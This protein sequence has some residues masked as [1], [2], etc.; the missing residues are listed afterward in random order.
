VVKGN[1]SPDMTKKADQAHVT[2]QKF[3][4]TIPYPYCQIPGHTEDRFWKKEKDVKA[5]NKGKR[6][7][8]AEVAF[9]LITCFHPGKREKF[10]GRNKHNIACI[11]TTL[12]R[13]SFIMLA[14]RQR[15]GILTPDTFIADSGDTCHRRN[16]TKGM[17]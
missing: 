10:V 14:L 17:N 4:R 7:E 15:E 12:R 11:H 5:Q 16:S 9:S 2:Q 8:K 13:P 1:D 3:D 6:E